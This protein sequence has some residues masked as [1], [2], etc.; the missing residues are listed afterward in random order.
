M[1]KDRLGG[2]HQSEAWS[3]PAL[4]Q[5]GLWLSLILLI[6]L[7]VVERAYVPSVHFLSD[8]ANGEYAWLL[9]AWVGAQALSTL[10]VLVALA[11]E[12]VVEF[13][14]T[15]ALLIALH[16]LLQ[17]VLI[18]VPI[19]PMA[20]AFS[21]DG[22]PTLSLSGWAHVLAGFAASVAVLVGTALV[23]RRMLSS[24]MTLRRWIVGFCALGWTAYL[25]MLAV[26]PVTFPAGLLQRVFV[27]AVWA[28]ML[29]V[30]F[31]LHPSSRR[32]R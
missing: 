23:S 27:M 15:P 32:D 26:R 25:V 17:P 13:R 10:A 21:G 1:N 5:I 6:A 16:V 28:W 14:S 20:S 2:V 7:H 12:R 19:D 3:Y 31:Q 9:N 22:A 4:A 18:L 29:A 11:D 24:N 30:S 8:Y